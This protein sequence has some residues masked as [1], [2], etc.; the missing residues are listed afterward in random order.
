PFVTSSVT[1]TS[2]RESGNRTDPITGPNLRTQH[3]AE[4]FVISSDYSH[5]SSANAADDEV[6]SIV[7]SSVPPPPILTAVVVTTTIVGATSILVHEL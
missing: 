1:P 2:E 5:H 6:T 4:R 3:P 7:W